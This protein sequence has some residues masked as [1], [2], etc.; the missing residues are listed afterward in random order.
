MWIYFAAFF[1]LQT[2]LKED[3]SIHGWVSFASLRAGSA[4]DD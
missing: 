3:L 2:D 4:D 1:C